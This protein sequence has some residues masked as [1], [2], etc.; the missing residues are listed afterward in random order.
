MS[1]PGS[2][3]PM[4]S[5]TSICNMALSWVG[6]APIT[7][8][9]DRSKTAEWCRNNYPFIR[10]AVMEAHMWSFATVRVISDNAEPDVDGWD[11][12]FMHSIPTNWLG[13][14]RCYR[15]ISSKNPREWIQST[16]WDTQGVY[17]RAVDE[18]LYMEGVIRTTD[19]GKFSPLFVQALAARLAADMA[20]PLTENRELQADMWGLYTNKIDEAAARD[21]QKSLSERVKR[22]NLVKRRRGGY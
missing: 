20:I 13:V 6:G 10:D 3:A 18:T 19:T 11:T 9:S 17:V 4:V 15:D 22:G 16:G 5:E 8:L 14:F 7:A 21:G 1:D 12:S 2:N